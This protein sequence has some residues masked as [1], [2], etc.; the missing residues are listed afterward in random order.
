MKIAVEIGNSKDAILEKT[1]F[2]VPET[3]NVHA[4]GES[5]TEPRRSPGSGSASSRITIVRY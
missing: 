5:A 1:R 3:F 2:D 4:H